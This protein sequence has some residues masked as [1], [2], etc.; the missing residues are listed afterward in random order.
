MN[1]NIIAICLYFGIMLMAAAVL[2]LTI[3]YFVRPNSAKKTAPA[4]MESKPVTKMNKFKS[5]EKEKI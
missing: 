1:G 4:A 5:P 2:V 3:V